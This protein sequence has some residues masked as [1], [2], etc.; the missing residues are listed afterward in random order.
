MEMM[1]FYPRP[2]LLIASLFLFVG[3]SRNENFT[4]CYENGQKEMEW[5]YKGGKSKK[6]TWWYENGQK[7]T[8]GNY[9]EPVEQ[10]IV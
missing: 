9:L 7:W 6:A 2:L 5:I 4:L 10:R 8:E 1:T 3:C